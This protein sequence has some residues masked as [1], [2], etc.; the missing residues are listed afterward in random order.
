MKEGVHTGYTGKSWL[1]AE[2]DA[3]LRKALLHC[4][5]YVRLY[6]HLPSKIL[7]VMRK[8][9]TYPTLSLTLE[10]RMHFNFNSSNNA[11]V[12]TPVHMAYT[13]T[14]TYVLPEHVATVETMSK[15]SERIKAY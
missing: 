9:T 5:L 8:R 13:C 14:C 10:L 12:P 7:P 15:A 1:Y 3:Q 2:F 6:T 4:T 11:R